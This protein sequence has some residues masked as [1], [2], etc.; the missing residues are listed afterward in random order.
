MTLP[1]HVRVLSSAAPSHPLV[2]L[3]IQL[4]LDSGDA[5]SVDVT[6]A[7]EVLLTL[8]DVDDSLVPTARL[9]PRELEVLALD[10]G[11]AARIA[12]SR[13]EPS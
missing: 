12:R 7:G 3:P 2:D 5:I 9:S 8:D 1:S 13:R 10:L 4:E 11:T 6:N